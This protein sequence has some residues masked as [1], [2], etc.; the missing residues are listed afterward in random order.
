MRVH[1]GIPDGP[2][3]AKIRPKV[4][5]GPAPCP[6]FF[7]EADDIVLQP[8]IWILR[9][10]YLFQDVQQLFSYSFDFTVVVFLC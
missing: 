1:I 2:V 3:E 9:L 4:Q 10:P 6:L 7:P 8:G 5:P